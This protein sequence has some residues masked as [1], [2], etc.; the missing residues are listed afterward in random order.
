M[1]I[2]IIDYGMG[3]LRNVQKA[4]EH[5]GVGAHISSQADDLSRADGLVLPG[6]GSVAGT[7]QIH[8]LSVQWNQDRLAAGIEGQEAALMRHPTALELLPPPPPE[9]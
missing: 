5:I 2:T 8:S 1:D 9:E 6:V 4:F 3:N 7:G